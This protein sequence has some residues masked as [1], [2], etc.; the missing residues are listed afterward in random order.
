MVPLYAARVQ[1]LGPTISSSSNTAHADIPSLKKVL[2][3]CCTLK[4]RSERD[5]NSNERRVL[6]RCSEV[7][8]E[9]NSGA[10]NSGPS[11]YFSDTLRIRRL[12]LI[13]SSISFRIS[14]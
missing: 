13:I 1:D 3:H 2:D 12:R 14:R 11:K 5:V 7:Q 9:G 10:T 8:I 6:S 4:S